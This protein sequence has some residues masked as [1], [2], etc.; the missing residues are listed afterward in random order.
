MKTK[1]FRKLNLSSVFLVVGGLIVAS[2]GGESDTASTLPVEV[3]VETTVPETTTTTTIP[4]VV[5]PL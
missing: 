3:I 1:S 2:C 5:N 4:V